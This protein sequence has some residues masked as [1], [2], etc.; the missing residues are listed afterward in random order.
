[1]AQGLESLQNKNDDSSSLSILQEDAVKES[2]IVAML[3]P[4]STLDEAR[5]GLNLLSLSSSDEAS[6][7]I[8]I[9]TTVGVHPYHVNDEGTSLDHDIES[10]RELLDDDNQH[11]NMFVPSANADSMPVTAFLLSR[12]NCHGFVPK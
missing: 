7:S 3:S 5:A 10:L 8:P 2:N 4:S 11:S 9:L 12:I 1:V 6:L